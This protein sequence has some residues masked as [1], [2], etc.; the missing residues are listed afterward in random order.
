MVVASIWRGGEAWWGSP[1][2][3]WYGASCSWP[4]HRTSQ[5]QQLQ[6]AYYS[7]MQ[8]AAFCSVCS[9]PSVLRREALQ[10]A[11]KRCKTLQ[12]KMVAVSAG[13]PVFGTILQDGTF[14]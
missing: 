6:P 9:A 5:R 2:P 7:C 11:A 1:S 4:P 13:N 10:N 12:A 3:S 14:P 8:H